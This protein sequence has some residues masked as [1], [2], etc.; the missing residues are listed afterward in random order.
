MSSEVICML[1][2]LAKTQKYFNILAEQHL[3]FP[4]GHPGRRGLCCLQGLWETTTQTDI[5]G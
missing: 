5:S 2:K 3:N 4:L 1:N